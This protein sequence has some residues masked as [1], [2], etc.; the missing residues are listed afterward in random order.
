MDCVI[1]CGDDASSSSSSS[2]SSLSSQQQ[3]FEQQ[4]HTPCADCDYPESPWASINNGVLICSKCSG[5]HRSLGV[6]NSFVQSLKLDVWSMHN[7]EIFRANRLG[8]TDN[9][10]VNE[11]LEHHVPSE[12][13]KPH[14]DSLRE[15]REAY[16]VEKY[17][18]RTFHSAN[19]GKRQ[20]PV[21]DTS[22]PTDQQLPA[23][24][25][26]LSL[27]PPPSSSSSTRKF[28]GSSSKTKSS[29]TPSSSSLHP[30]SEIS[31]SGSIEFIGVLCVHLHTATD[32]V[33]SDIIGGADPYC[34]VGMG[35]QILKSKVIKKT[36][37]PRWD[38]KLMFSWNGVDPLMINVMDKDMFKR[39]DPMGVLQ[40]DLKPLYDA[41]MIA[42]KETMDYDL[43]LDNTKHGSIQFSLTL[44]ILV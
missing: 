42:S 41:G 9:A 30:N 39:D 4:I 5:V 20:P 28:F 25:S 36:L 13:I 31:S 14:H 27:S 24:S 10:V 7:I 38:E 17:K 18:H 37:N 23:T 40:F 43:K 26:P 8:A 15:T 34:I 33:R 11:V 1:T 32:L 35:N 44:E 16:I 22:I 6:E 12:F 21:K 3:L 2:S 29:A 19:G